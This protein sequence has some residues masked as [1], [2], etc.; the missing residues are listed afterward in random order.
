M[1]QSVC[2]CVCVCASVSV[3]VCVCVC[4]CVE[5]K[6]LHTQGLPTLCVSVCVCESVCVCVCVG[7]GDGRCCSSP[8]GYATIC[9]NLKAF[10]ARPMQILLWPT[11]RHRLAR[12]SKEL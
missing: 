8:L 6:P 11:G 10:K 5:D 12:L 4:V 7:V 1:S 3:C 2:V 9:C